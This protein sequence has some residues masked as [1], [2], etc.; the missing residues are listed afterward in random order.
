MHFIWRGNVAN[1]WWPS[2]QWSNHWWPSHQWLDQGPHNPKW[3]VASPSL[4][5]PGLEKKT[6]TVSIFSL[7]GANHFTGNNTRDKDVIKL[8]KLFCAHFWSGYYTPFSTHGNTLPSSFLLS[9]CFLSCPLLYSLLSVNLEYNEQEGYAGE[10]LIFDTHSQ[11]LCWPIDRGTGFV[12]SQVF[13]TV[14]RVALPAKRRL[15]HHL[16]YLQNIFK[17]WSAGESLK[18]PTWIDLEGE[19]RWEIMLRFKSNL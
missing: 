9:S 4:T 13:F 2:H 3:A 17:Y 19:S 1:H 7:T 15:N 11:Q 10:I 18:T 16:N 8:R 12:V 6:Y 5:L 14:W